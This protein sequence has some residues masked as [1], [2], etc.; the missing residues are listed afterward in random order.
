MSGIIGVVSRF[1][2]IGGAILVAVWAYKE[3][4]RRQQE[5]EQQ[6]QQQQVTNRGSSGHCNSNNTSVKKSKAPPQPGNICSICQDDLSVPLEILPCTHI[7]HRVCIR[8][9]FM[10]RMVCPYCNTA[11]SGEDVEEYQKRLNIITLHD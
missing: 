11:I 8:Q 4:V 9:W 3:Y 10:T 1:S 2:V 5:Q 7:F 6:L